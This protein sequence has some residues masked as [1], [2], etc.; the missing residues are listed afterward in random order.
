MKRDCGDKNFPIW[1][2][3]DSEPENWK[4]VLTSPFD[5]RHP[6]RHN[7]WTSILDKIQ[8]NIFRT[9]FNRINVERIYI[10][11][12]VDDPIKKPKYNQIN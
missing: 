6:I 10:R 2:L 7:I 3:G 8:D 4:D 11:N 12:A 5:S 9:N 1:L